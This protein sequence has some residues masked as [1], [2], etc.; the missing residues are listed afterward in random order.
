MGASGRMVALPS[1]TSAASGRPRARDYI[2]GAFSHVENVLQSERGIG[3]AN[4]AAGWRPLGDTG[5]QTR[6]A[7]TGLLGPEAVVS[8]E[9]EALYQSTYTAVVRFL[10]RK[11]WDAERAEDLAQEVF[12]LSLIHISEPTR[13]LSIS[14]A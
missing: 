13:L 3:C 5:E 4:S 10:Y 12:V 7:A 6:D 9:F 1:R 11:V 8:D 14:Y 2:Q